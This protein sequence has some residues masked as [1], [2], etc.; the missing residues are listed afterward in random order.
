MAPRIA[1]LTSPRLVGAPSRMT[2][3]AKTGR[4]SRPP[5]PSSENAARPPTVERFL[6][7][8]MKATTV[9]IDSGHL[10]LITHPDEVTQLIL[11]A[12]QAARLNAL[13]APFGSDRAA[14]S[15][16]YGLRRSWWSGR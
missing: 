16:G 5:T 6:A 9:E 10:S 8:R 1:A 3:R 2:G 12:V 11:A 4:A 7:D 15:P 14:G 13:P